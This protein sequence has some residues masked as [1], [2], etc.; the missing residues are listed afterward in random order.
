[1]SSVLVMT[2]VKQRHRPMSAYDS[3]AVSS[4]PRKYIIVS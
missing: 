3:D 2:Y 1:M 4:G